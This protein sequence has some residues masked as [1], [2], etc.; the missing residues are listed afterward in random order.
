MKKVN[1]KKLNLVLLVSFTIYLILGNISG[2]PIIK[3]K[4][5]G[6][7]N[8]E[9][10]SV[11]IIGSLIGLFGIFVIYNSLVKMKKLMYRFFLVV[12]ILL[13]LAFI[14]GDKDLLDIAILFLVTIPT[15]ICT[16]LILKSHNFCNK[17]RN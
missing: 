11:S 9:V 17:A 15:A 5:S 16:Y 2:Y 4:M 6:M 7:S 8:V 1:I 10:L 14:F 3:N 12:S 13:L